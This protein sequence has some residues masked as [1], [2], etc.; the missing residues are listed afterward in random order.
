[1]LQHTIT[2]RSGQLEPEG[3][4][5]VRKTWETQP[6]LTWSLGSSVETQS[7]WHFPGSPCLLAASQ[8]WNAGFSHLLFLPFFE[9]SVLA[10]LFSFFSL[11][12]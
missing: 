12:K 3:I 4:H 9:N 2:Y 5:L 11:K 1:M 10:V 6:H 8:I 7:A